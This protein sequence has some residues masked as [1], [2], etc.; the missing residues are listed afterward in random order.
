[1]VECRELGCQVLRDVCEIW[2]TSSGVVVLP[3]SWKFVNC[4]SNL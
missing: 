1:M 4:Y 3:N 2:S